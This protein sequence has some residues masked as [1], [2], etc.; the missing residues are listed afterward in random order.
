MTSDN[1]VTKIGK[2][3]LYLAI[4][5]GKMRAMDGGMYVLICCSAHPD[6][7]FSRAAFSRSNMIGADSLPVN[8]GRQ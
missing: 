3:S 2:S 5:R 6:I 8:L 7:A 4:Y 1:T